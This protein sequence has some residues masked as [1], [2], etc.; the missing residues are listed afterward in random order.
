MIPNKLHIYF[1]RDQSPA[2]DEVCKK[3]HSE[4]R[5][6]EISKHADAEFFMYIITFTLP[7]DIYMFGYLSRELYKYFPDAT[8]STGDDGSTES[9]IL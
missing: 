3:M 5:I 8:F 2:V 9:E 6:K 4:G 1:G 7:Y